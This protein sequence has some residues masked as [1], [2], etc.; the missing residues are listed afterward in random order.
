MLWWCDCGQTLWK[1]CI[2][3]EEEHTKLGLISVLQI[4][5]RATFDHQQMVGFGNKQIW[6]RNLQWLK[7]GP[8]LLLF[9][10]GYWDCTFA[11]IWELI[12]HYICWSQYL[13]LTFAHRTNELLQRCRRLH[14]PKGSI[15]LAIWKNKHLIEKKLNHFLPHLGITVTS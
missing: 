13:L 15:L 9:L 1:E 5:K 4:E 3:T 12:H 11:V 14:H 6:S 2:R 10:G 7:Q 8:F